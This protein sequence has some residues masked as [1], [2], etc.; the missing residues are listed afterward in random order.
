[1]QEKQSIGYLF[2][3]IEDAFVSIWARKSVCPSRSDLLYIK[4][5]FTQNRSNL[6]Q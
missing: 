6:N 3:K 2:T 1:M 5:V 4:R